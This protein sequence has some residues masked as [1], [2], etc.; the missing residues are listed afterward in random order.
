MRVASRDWRV[1]ERT[2]GTRCTWLSRE[3]AREPEAC[4]SRPTE[5]WRMVASLPA[6]SEP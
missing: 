1:V 3:E 2:R 5:P 4:V 6:M